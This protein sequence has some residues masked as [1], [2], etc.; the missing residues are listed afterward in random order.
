MKYED[1]LQELSRQQ[2]MFLKSI[3]DLQD[4][5]SD[6]KKEIEPLE[7]DAQQE[8]LS[9][10]EGTKS[11]VESREIVVKQILR[12]SERYLVL[13]EEIRLAEKQLNTSKACVKSIESDLDSTRAM[14]HYDIAILEKERAQIEAD[15]ID[16]QIAFHRAKLKSGT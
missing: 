1:R 10:L 11:N 16:K 3:T 9:R 8:M 14:M 7:L 12:R 6:A 15:R 13:C 4:T 2:A 5:I